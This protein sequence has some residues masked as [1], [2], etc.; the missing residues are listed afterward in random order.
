[1]FI[2]VKVKVATSTRALDGDILEFLSLYQYCLL[3]LLRFT[4][5]AARLEGDQH[6]DDA[7]T[8]AWVFDSYASMMKNIF[9]RYLLSWRD[10]RCSCS[11]CI[12]DTFL[13]PSTSS[14][15]SK[16]ARARYCTCDYSTSSTTSQKQQRDDTDNK[17]KVFRLHE[18]VFKCLLVCINVNF[19]IIAVP[20]STVI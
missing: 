15:A 6:H 1:M 18:F 14:S 3:L 9:T 5:R 19:T 10:C 13:K 4:L 8:V 12:S 2:C 7:P 17:V 16:R 20:S 11:C